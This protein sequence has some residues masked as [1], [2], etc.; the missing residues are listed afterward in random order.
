MKLNGQNIPLEREISVQ[1]LLIGAGFQLERIAV[2]LNGEIL[3]RS[4]LSSVLIKPD[5][6]LEVLSFVGGG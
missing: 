6:E 5:D 2:M 3:P 1:E 4:Q